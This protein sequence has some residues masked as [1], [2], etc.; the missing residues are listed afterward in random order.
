MGGG[1]KCNHLYRPGHQ[2]MEE[3]EK[4][5]KRDRERGYVWEHEISRDPDL[6]DSSSLAMNLGAFRSW[7]G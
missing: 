7:I 5:G 6:Q 3:N 2:G 4:S 1:L